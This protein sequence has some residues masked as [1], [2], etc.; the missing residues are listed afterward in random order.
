ML[1]SRYVKHLRA[2]I[3]KI[4]RSFHQLSIFGE[5]TAD[6]SVDEQPQKEIKQHKIVVRLWTK[7]GIRNTV[8]RYNH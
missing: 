6:V 3:M 1:H 2:S 4:I 8:E 7:G 5:H